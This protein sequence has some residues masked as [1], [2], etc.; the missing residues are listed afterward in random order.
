MYFVGVLNSIR[1]FGSKQAHRMDSL[2][3]FKVDQVQ[4]VSPFNSIFE[5]GLGLRSSFDAGLI[6]NRLI[7]RRAF[8]TYWHDRP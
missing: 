5:M 3:V 6:E 4:A 7:P 8:T 1:G 2:S